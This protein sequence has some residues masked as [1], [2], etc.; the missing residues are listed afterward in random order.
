MR[1]IRSKIQAYHKW[2]IVWHCYM[3]KYRGILTQSALLARPPIFG[4]Y[5][6]KYLG[7][8]LKN[9]NIIFPRLEFNFDATVTWTQY[10]T[11]WPSVT[12]FHFFYI[13]KYISSQGQKETSSN[14]HHKCKLLSY[15]TSTNFIKFSFAEPQLFKKYLALRSFNK[16]TRFWGWTRSLKLYIVMKQF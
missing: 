13:V 5:Y 4:T 7:H 12:K 9:N 2:W 11:W 6:R 15:I 14:F 3:R 10:I 1:I 8:I 16:W